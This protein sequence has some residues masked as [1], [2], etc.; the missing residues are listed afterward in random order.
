MASSTTASA[1]A[2]SISAFAAFRHVRCGVRRAGRDRLAPAPSAIFI[3]EK[4]RNPI[5]ERRVLAPYSYVV[6][7]DR[8]TRQKSRRLRQHVVPAYVL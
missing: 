2:I 8:A 5:G 7:T 4:R 6:I 1:R 3:I